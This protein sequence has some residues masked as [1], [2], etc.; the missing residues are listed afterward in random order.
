[1]SPNQIPRTLSTLNGEQHSWFLS[2]KCLTTLVSRL[3]E[4]ASLRF[5][6]E[7]S[8]TAALEN[9]SRR[10]HIHFIS[11]IKELSSK[12]Q[13]LESFIALSN[14]RLI[15]I[16]SV[17]AVVRRDFGVGG[18]ESGN[19]AAQIS[20]VL[21]TESS[22]MKAL[23]EHYNL[24]VVATNHVTSASTRGS[25]DRYATAALGNTWHHATN[26]R[27]VLEYLVPG[28][29]QGRGREIRTAGD[30]MTEGRIV[31]RVL[32]I[33]KSSVSAA[34]S[35]PSTIDGTGLRLGIPAAN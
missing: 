29:V 17:A 32:R 27:I 16:D 15:V 5:P 23:A 11:S 26:L 3:L 12:L 18:G 14:V 10:I 30:T 13:E 21:A 6:E 4:I 31:G 24:A 33:A 7:Y 9:L 1:M 22:R 28:G 34:T 2:A 19:N 25:E 20:D 35:F 8:S